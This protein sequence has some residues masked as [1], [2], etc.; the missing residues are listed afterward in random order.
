M[1]EDASVGQLLQQARL[2]QGLSREALAEELKLPLRHLEAIESDDWVALPPGRPRPLARQLADRLGVDLDYHTGAFQIV[3][4]VRELDPPDPR[5]ERLERVVMGVLTAASV[6]VVLW[7]VVPGPR[8]GRKPAP[9]DL[10]LLAKPSLPPPPAPSASP[11][12]VLGELLPE[13]PLNEQGALV[14]LRAM[15]TCNVKIEPEEG[16]GGQP[17]ARTLRVSEP[18]RLRV[19]GPFTIV[20]DNAGVVNVEVAGHR[21]PH[22]QS[23]GEGWTGRFDGEGRWLQPRPPELPE[24]APLPDDDEAEGGTKP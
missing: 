5:Q 24:G 7:L 19:K 14:S 4:G 3:P 10:A 20:L 15:D 18:W 23:V 6:L 13:A 9:S 21:I 16:A 11:Y 17:M 8:L 2:A 1:S 22:G 12:P